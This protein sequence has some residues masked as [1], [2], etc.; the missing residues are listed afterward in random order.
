M[1]F[2]WEDV[3]GRQYMEDKMSFNR[4]LP[5]GFSYYGVYDG[6]GGSF[7]SS[8]LQA[9]MSK[10]I[11]A[12][13]TKEFDKHDTSNVDVSKLLFEAIKSIVNDIPYKNATETGSTA[14]IVLQKDDTIW[15]A[16][17][18]DSRAIMN[19]GHQCISLTRDHKPDNIHEYKRIVKLGGS[20]TKVVPYDVYRVNG[21]LAVSRAIGDFSLSPHVTWNP[22]IT[23]KH[24]KSNNHYVFIAT[25]GVWDVIDNGEVINIINKKAMDENWQDIGNTLISLARSRNSTDNISCM[26]VIL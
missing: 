22:E 15:V 3:G 1:V 5:Y 14:V 21:V 24:I 13:I 6:H 8:Y 4:Q 17:I 7:V 11:K 26:L 9:N 10:A 20:V 18:G 25:D 16:N 23:T 12:Q 19:K 2:M